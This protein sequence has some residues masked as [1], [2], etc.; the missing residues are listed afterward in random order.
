[1]LLEVILL[2]CFFCK[3]YLVFFQVSSLCSLR[4][5]A[6]KVVPTKHCQ[7]WVLSYR[8]GLKYNQM[9]VG[10]SQKLLTLFIYLPYLVDSQLLQIKGFI[11]WSVFIFLHWQQC[12]VPSKT[13]NTSMS[14]YRL[15]L[16]TSLSSSYSVTC[17]IAVF[18]N[19][20]LP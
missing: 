13:M 2:L 11:S 18:S 1:M 19:R 9:L 4:L 8:M 5:L 3:Q 10:C 12:R 6:N 17:I 7:E 14:G 15:Q 20:L 16:A